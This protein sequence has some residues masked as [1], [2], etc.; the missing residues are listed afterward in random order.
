[1]N[2]NIIICLVII[3]FC[4][5]IYG[6]YKNQKIIY[7]NSKFIVSTNLNMDSTDVDVSNIENQLAIVDTIFSLLLCPDSF[8][9]PRDS[10]PSPLLIYMTKKDGLTGFQDSKSYR[11]VK[12]DNN[13]R[14]KRVWNTP[15][16]R[17]ITEE[18]SEYFLKHNKIMPGMHIIGENDAIEKAQVFFSKLLK[19][20]G[21][22]N[23]M[24]IYDSII[25]N[26]YLDHDC[27]QINFL[28]K[29]KNHIR[30]NREAEIAVSPLNGQILQFYTPMGLQL[31]RDINY[32]PKFKYEQVNELI[33][34]LRINNRLHMSVYRSLLL[35]PKIFNFNKWVWVLFGLKDSTSYHANLLIIDSN[36][37][38]ILMN[39]FDTNTNR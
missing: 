2:K 24:R 28:P 15:C 38:E 11:V 32:K 29:I 33:E 21:M 20:Y 34:D 30:D 25:V 26:L 7:K 10:L 12:L 8:N 13:N 35:E 3:S 31:N 23:D 22:Q 39:E 18:E 4:F 9:V 14:I 37:G 1:M 16:A 17:K 6:F 27:Y 5:S 36:T 19:Y